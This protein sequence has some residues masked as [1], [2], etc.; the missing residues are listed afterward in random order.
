MGL[1]KY[2]EDNYELYVERLST[3]GLNMTR[4]WMGLSRTDNKTDKK[5][6]Y[7]EKRR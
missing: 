1:A 5:E 2:D 3:K 6:D 4:E 7:H